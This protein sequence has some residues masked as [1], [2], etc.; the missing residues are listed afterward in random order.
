MNIP[1]RKEAS[2][3]IANFCHEDY[4]MYVDGILSDMETAERSGNKREV[5]HLRKY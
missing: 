2:K 1:E 4:R 3:A 5:A